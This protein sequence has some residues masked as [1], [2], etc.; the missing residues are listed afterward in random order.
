MQ[1]TRVGGLCLIFLLLLPWNGSAKCTKTSTLSSSSSCSS[2]SSSY[3][4]DGA[5][6][7]YT[8]TNGQ[9]ALIITGPDIQESPELEATFINKFRS[10]LNI[11]PEMVTGTKVLYH[12]S[13]NR[14]DESCKSTRDADSRSSSHS[15]SRSTSTSS[16]S[17]THSN[18]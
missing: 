4:Q 5:T 16:T 8:N 18:R 11:P 1:L 7:D 10:E 14:P 2:S 3:S 13:K 9:E 17:H 6:F 15:Y 12:A